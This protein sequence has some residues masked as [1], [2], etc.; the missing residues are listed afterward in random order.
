MSIIILVASFIVAVIGIFS[1]NTAR[2]GQRATLGLRARGVILLTL[3]FIGMAAAIVKELADA[4]EK[5]S[6]RDQQGKLYA[7]L[8]AFSY[9]Q[10]ANLDQKARDLAQQ[11]ELLAARETAID[12]QT[13]LIRDLKKYIT[14]P[15]A[16]LKERELQV[17][18]AV[19]AAKAPNAGASAN[20]LTRPV[21]QPQPKLHWDDYHYTARN[22][23][24]ISLRSGP[25][26]QYP[27]VK[28]VSE[29]TFLDP[30]DP[31]VIRGGEVWIRLRYTRGLFPRDGYAKKD[32]LQQHSN[33]LK[34]LH[35]ESTP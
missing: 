1:D 35:L 27:V 13:E 31:D 7:R 23:K 16:S 2:R 4:A 34:K 8:E 9:A 33:F 17:D 20:T 12:V 25:G 24:N 32:D 28:E 5:R 22:G 30:L 14:T 26:T 10:A 15:N 21:T 18:R 19:S 6:D 29:S 3:A 11:K